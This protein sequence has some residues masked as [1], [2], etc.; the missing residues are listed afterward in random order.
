MNSFAQ[1]TKTVFFATSTLVAASLAPAASAADVRLAWNAVSS[2]AVTGY[3]VHWGTGSRSYTSQLNPGEVTSA[4]V[5]GLTEGRRYYFAVTAIDSQGARSAYSNEVSVIASSATD[6]TAPSA[7]PSFTATAGSPSTVS[8]DW[9]AASDNVGVTGYRIERCSG[10]SC[11]SFAQIATTT[12]AT[13]YSNTGLTASTHYRYRVRAIDAAGNLGAYSVVASVTT[14]SV[15]DATAPSAPGSFNASAS[16]STSI[17]LS[18]SAATDNVGVAGY[19]IERCTGSS[20]TGFAQI[21]TTTGRSYSNTGLATGSTYRYRVRAYDAAGNVGPYSAVDSATPGANATFEDAGLAVDQHDRSNT[22]SNLNGILEPGE[23]VYVVPRWRMA[24]GSTVSLSGSAAISGTGSGAFRLDDSVASYGSVSAGQ[25]INCYSAASNCFR[26]TVDKDSSRPSTRWE[27]I[28][29]ETLSNGQRQVRS[30]H[31]GRSFTDVSPSNV[32]YDEIESLVR[33][34]VSHG[35]SDRTFR[36]SDPATRMTTAMF[37]ARALQDGRG[38]SGVPGSGSIGG[39]AYNCSAGGRS[40]YADVAAT[41]VGCKHVHYLAARN[42]AVRHACSASNSACADDELT[43][44][45]LAVMLA[46]AM[47]GGDS[48]VP[49]SGTF[50]DSGSSRSYNCG[51]SSGSRLPDVPVSASYC[52]HAHYLWARGVLSAFGDGTFRPHD[53]VSRGRLARAIADAFELT[54]E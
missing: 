14:P 38:D 30:I 13:S 32:D 2:A 49:M 34:N 45:T 40:L 27:L 39:V 54:T 18:W 26:I 33:N 1:W 24:S 41:E 46:G 21:A 43:R 20:C 36:P 4:T 28:L 16:G 11:T 6:A 12:T 53:V 3:T 17:A 15:V 37:V 52:R 5:T 25:T 29:T 35:L 44:R 48:S 22:S 19:R 31:I 47:A 50:S 9:D 51:T 42:V 8:L 10:A 23:T 7:P